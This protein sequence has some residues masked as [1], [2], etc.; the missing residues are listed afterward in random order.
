[1]RLNRR[2]RAEEAGNKAAFKMLFPLV[3]CLVPAVY[4]ML[5]GPAVLDIRD[6]FRRE[7][8]PGGVLSREQVPSLLQA[9][10]ERPRRPP[11]Q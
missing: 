7:R 4:L 1:M 8:Q 9:P 3:F 6:F 2:Q 11:A 5:L 10:P